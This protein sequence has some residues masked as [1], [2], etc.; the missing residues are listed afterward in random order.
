MFTSQS[1]T[2]RA[3]FLQAWSSLLAAMLKRWWLLANIYNLKTSER[4]YV[5]SDSRI[6]VEIP[7]CC[8]PNITV[9]RR[10]ALTLVMPS[11]TL[12]AKASYKKLPGLL[13]L[14]TTHLQWTQ[15]GKKAPSVRI[16]HNEASCWCCFCVQMRDS[17]TSF[18]H[19]FV[20][21][22]AQPW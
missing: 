12:T 2:Q 3:V 14:T 16:P 15:D 22:K 13:E 20:A 21:K 6:C 10:R 4:S 8:L 18:K 7:E 1:Q 5:E 11:P 19:S 9:G 17:L